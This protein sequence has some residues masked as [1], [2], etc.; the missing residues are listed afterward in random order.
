[1]KS[2]KDIKEFNIDSFED[3]RGEI[4]TTY[5][6]KNFDLD[7][8]HDKIT[9]RPKN[10][11]VGIHGDYKT[12][13]LITCLYGKVFIAVIDN[14]EDS[15]DYN[16]HKTFILSGSNKKQL[17]IPPGMGNSFLVLSDVCVYSY[18]LAYEG[19][20]IDCDEQFTLKWDDPKYNIYWPITNP[21]MSERDANA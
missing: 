2:L 13:K 19:D 3:F 17:L 8:N 6:K 20:Y 1:M 9:V 4:Y 14:R 12:H 21:I 7:F 5:E 11:L 18:K 15:I 10:C 16:K